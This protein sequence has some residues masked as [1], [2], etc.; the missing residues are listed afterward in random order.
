[1]KQLAARHPVVDSYT[2]GDDLFNLHNTWD[3]ERIM[4]CHCDDGYGG[5]DCS[6]LVCPTGKDPTQTGSPVYETQ[7][8]RCTRSSAET[9]DTSTWGVYLSYRRQRTALISVT[10]SASVLQ[11][12]LEALSVVESGGVTVTYSA[13][14]TEFCEL[15]NA[16]ETFT[17]VAWTREGGDLPLL[18][19][20]SPLHGN[21]IAVNVTESVAGTHHV[22][23]CSNKGTCNT[24]TGVCQCYR[25][26][27][28]SDGMFSVGASGDCGYLRPII[29]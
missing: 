18:Q 3:A 20:V 21:G 23:S 19:H 12:A 13:G 28:S 25:G 17:T 27:G 7:E 8:I 14:K 2:Y 10:A 26:W 22:A 5:Y 4:G 24:Q 11:Q 16:T 15:D 6:K 29:I 9:S 1:M